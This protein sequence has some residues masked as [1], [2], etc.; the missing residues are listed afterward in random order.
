[1]GVPPDDVT[2]PLEQ[3][4]T[5]DAGAA[6][7]ANPI[8]RIGST[9][10][11]GNRRGEVHGLNALTGK[12]HGDHAFGE[13]V[14]GGSVVDGQ[15]VIV[16]VKVGSYGVQALDLTTGKRIWH[17]EFEPV[18]ADLAA[19]GNRVV[20]TGLEGGVASFDAASGEQLW[21]SRPAAAPYLAAPIIHIDDVIAIN[22][23]GVVHI[24]NAASGE[25]IS[26]FDLGE[27]VHRNA[28][29]HS[30][31]LI[32]PTT[33][34]RVHAFDP[35][36]QRLVWTFDSRNDLARMATS[37]VMEGTVI[38]PASSGHVYALDLSSGDPRWHQDIGAAVTAPPLPVGATVFIGTMDA[39]LI[40]IGAES[41]EVRG[42]QALRGRVKSAMKADANGLLIAVE[43]RHVVRYAWGIR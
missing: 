33:R 22:R 7:G 10:L 20:A 12:R 40:Q 43:P 35:A 21:N 14:E 18:E 38:A 36:S 24:L 3:L 17:A 2:L 23:E 27:P 11:V 37:A 25:L 30:G 31:I 9:I 6:F 29:L 39:R 8:T 15:T 13:S 32:I 1:M 4:W 5:Y 28:T 19:F 42:E 26:E 16:P 34:G 41:G